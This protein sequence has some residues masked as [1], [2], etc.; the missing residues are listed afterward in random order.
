MLYL[1]LTGDGV[2]SKCL[3]ENLKKWK[4]QE[5]Q[6]LDL[7]PESVDSVRVKSSEEEVI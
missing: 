4:E 2:F 5:E 7:V 3:E 1:P 6:L